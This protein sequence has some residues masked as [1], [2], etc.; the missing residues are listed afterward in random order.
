MGHCQLGTMLYMS[1]EQ[2]ECNVKEISCQADVWAMGIIWHE[3][4]THYTPFEPAASDNDKGASSGSSGRCRSLTK[5]QESAMITRICED[6]PCSMPILAQINVPQQIVKIISKCLQT[7]KKR[8]YERAGDMLQHMTDVFEEI[9]N[10]PQLKK[11]S[12]TQQA[13][14]GEL[15]FKHWSVEDVAKLLRDVCK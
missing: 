7:D 4:L 9:E 8:R 12:S 2:L 13:S 6:A 10:K 5:K 15:P 11:A 3:L 14:Q 1:P